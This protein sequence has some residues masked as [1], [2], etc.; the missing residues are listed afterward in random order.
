M[1]CND[2]IGDNRENGGLTSSPRGPISPGGP[3]RSRYILPSEP[4]TRRPSPGSWVRRWEV[5]R[6]LIADVR[7]CGTASPVR[8]DSGKDVSS[9][10]SVRTFKPSDVTRAV[11]IPGSS[12]SPNEGFLAPLSVR[13]AFLSAV[14]LSSTSLDDSPGFSL[15]L[16][17]R[18]FRAGFAWRWTFP[19]LWKRPVSSST[20]T[21]PPPPPPPDPPDRLN[22][23]SVVPS[24]RKLPCF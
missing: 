4:W 8:R 17:R 11:R 7:L 6:S 1:E 24:R 2:K 18:P 5:V 15:G 14:M 20:K 21:T 16:P 23:D 13:L 12:G 19:L 9:V 3:L 10:A 22:P